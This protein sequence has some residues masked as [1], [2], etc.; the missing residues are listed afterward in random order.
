MP[1]HRIDRAP[2]VFFLLTCTYSWILWLPSILTGLGVEFGLDAATYTGVTVSLGAFAPLSAAL[3]LIVRRHGWKEGWRFFRQAFDFRAKLVYFLLALAVPLVVHAV[4]HYLAPLFNLQ[5]ADS[6][7]GMVVPE[8]VSPWLLVVPIFLFY[9]VLGGG[10]EEFGWRGYAQQPLQERFGVI[11]ASLLIGMVWSVWHLPLWVMPGEA[12]AAYPFLAFLVATTS[13]AV[14]YALLY[15]ASGQKLIIPLFYHAMDNMAV[16][17][18]PY[19]HMM[20]GKPETAFWV[21]AGANV[22]A[23]LVAAYIIR[24]RRS[25]HYGTEYLGAG[26]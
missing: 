3:T 6:L 4:A 9:L 20:A 5:V 21:F 25:V 19:L 22:L 17:F 14:V 24:R 18:F 10:Q 23:G 1:N 11:P 7:L 13:R 15:N 16:G 26:S 2:F 8:G 12:H